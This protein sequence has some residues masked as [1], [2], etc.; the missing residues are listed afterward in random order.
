MSNYRRNRHGQTYF[1]TVVTDHRRPIL[2]TE[3]GRSA[4][5]KAIRETRQETPFNILAIVLLPDH[6]HTIWEM[7][8]G[9][10]DY[11][12]R[13]KTIKTRFTKIWRKRGGSTNPRSQ[14]RQIRG[15]HGVW[16]RRFFEHTC[17]DEED[18]NRCIDYVHVNPLRHGLVDRVSDWPWSSFHRYV[19]I[20]SYS[21][22]WGG[23]CEWYGD[24]FDLYE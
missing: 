18:L 24:E 9:D 10:T 1:F 11:S 16:Q 3:L 20:G 2:T 17:R 4:L 19:K 5:R 22:D 13:W 8:H 23:A 15:E 7:P 14:S 12:T 6:L 21:V